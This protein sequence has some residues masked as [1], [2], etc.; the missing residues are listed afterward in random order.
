MGRGDR[1][2]SAKMRQR[3]AW[4][5]KKARE[6]ARRG[7]PKAA[8]ARLAAARHP[9]CLPEPPPRI[10]WSEARDMAPKWQCPSCRQ[11]QNFESEEQCFSCSE[12]RPR[13]PLP[14]QIPLEPPLPVPRR[15]VSAAL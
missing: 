13:V 5:K 14:K 8:D 6:Q 2:K 15:A 12:P 10:W 3:N 1:R 4:R 11:H 7:D 9:K